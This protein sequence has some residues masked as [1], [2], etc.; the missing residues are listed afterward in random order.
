MR[1]SQILDTL[2]TET[3]P[4]ATICLKEQ[5]KIEEHK[6]H[7]EHILKKHK[8]LEKGYTTSGKYKRLDRTSNDLS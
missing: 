5:Q 4:S 7:K 2:Y 8:K 3:L 1:N 6:K